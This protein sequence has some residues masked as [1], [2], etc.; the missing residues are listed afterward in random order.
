MENPSRSMLRTP[1]RVAGP[2]PA[3]VAR[4]Q[5][6][7]PACSKGSRQALTAVPVPLICW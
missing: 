3:S 1:T 7:E 2:Y 5:S 6:S 4:R